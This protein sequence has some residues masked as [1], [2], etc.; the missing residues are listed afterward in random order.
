[1]IGGLSPS[2][3]FVECIS[4]HF[5]LIDWANACHMLSFGHQ[6]WLPSYN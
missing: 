3:I 2:L 4:M 1:V 5:T 6:L